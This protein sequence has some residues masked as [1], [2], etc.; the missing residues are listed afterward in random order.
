MKPWQAIVKLHEHLTAYVKKNTLVPVIMVKGGGEVPGALHKRIFSFNA[1]TGVS[2]LGDELLIISIEESIGE[3]TFT[4]GLFYVCKDRESRSDIQYPDI[5][6]NP[7]T[8][9]TDDE[10]A[11]LMAGLELCLTND[12]A[13]NP[14]PANEPVH[15]PPRTLH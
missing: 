2:H 12:R 9:F 15:T 1:G 5:D 7:G 13:A 3:D 6:G 11:T 4:R 14:E 10:L 8:P